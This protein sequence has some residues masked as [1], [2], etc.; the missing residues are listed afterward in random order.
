LS[1]ISEGESFSSIA[2]ANL[3]SVKVVFLCMWLYNEEILG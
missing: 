1:S 2:N 3:G